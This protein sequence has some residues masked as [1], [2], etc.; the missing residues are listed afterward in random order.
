MHDHQ[1][2]KLFIVKQ[3]LPVGTFKNVCWTV[4]RICILILGCKGL[5]SIFLA[6]PVAE[7][8]WLIWQTIVLLRKIKTQQN[9][10]PS[11]QTDNKNYCLVI[12][13]LFCLFN[14]LDACNP[15]MVN[16]KGKK[17][18]VLNNFDNIYY[19]ITYRLWKHPHS[20]RWSTI[21]I[22]GLSKPLIL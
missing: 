16:Y 10:N 12:L 19:Q 6:I 14:L 8:C 3:I 22:E 5:R 11:S 1:L 18:D 15:C 9:N 7:R 20:S 4:W 17:F 2:K 21:V 13:P